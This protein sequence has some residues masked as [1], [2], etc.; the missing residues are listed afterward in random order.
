MLGGLRSCSTG[1]RSRP[2]RTVDAAR[3]CC[4]RSHLFITRRAA[5]QYACAAAASRLDLREAA[6]AEE[7]LF[8]G[9]VPFGASRTGAL[10]SV[11]AYSWFLGGDR[12]RFA[13]MSGLAFSLAGIFGGLAAAIATHALFM[14]LTALL[15]LHGVARSRVV[16][17][18]KGTRDLSQTNAAKGSSKKRK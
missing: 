5:I 15:F 2:R 6:L 1:L 17:G 18:D 4:R 9:A 13:A 10:A 14:M 12:A 11:V 7:V 3:R 8:R 16:A